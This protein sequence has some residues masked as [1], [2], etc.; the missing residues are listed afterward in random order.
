VTRELE[1]LELSRDH[2]K[3][4]LE[5]I[6]TMHKLSRSR[7]SLIPFVG[8]ALS[9]LFGTLNEGD[10]QAIKNN[11]RKIAT[12]HARL[13]HIVHASISILRTTQGQVVENRKT[14]NNIIEQLVIINQRASNL[15]ENVY[16]LGSHVEMYTLLD[17]A[18]S[19]TP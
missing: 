4:K 8:K 16:E 3:G 19:Q 14:L 17:R 18:I 15:S 12:S 11:V 9:F 5:E 7:R 6:K 13:Q 2:L 10:V 1:G